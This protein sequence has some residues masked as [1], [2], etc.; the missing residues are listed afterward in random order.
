MTRATIDRL[1]LARWPDTHRE[2]WAR[3]IGHQ[4]W[5]GSY[6]RRIRTGVE[7]WFGFAGA[8][9]LPTP[10]GVAAYEAV[11]VQRLSARTAPTYLQLLA[12]GIQ[13]VAPAADWHWP[14]RHVLAR[15]PRP[16]RRE[17]VPEDG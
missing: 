14:V 3:N 5:P 11:P 15:L 9:T 7:R 8:G 13:L 2:A 10:E 12:Y 1:P 16:V 6:A 17:R 4:S